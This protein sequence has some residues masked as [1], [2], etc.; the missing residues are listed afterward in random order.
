[1][2]IKRATAVALLVA[3]G[4][5]KADGWDDAKLKDRI[6][7]VPQKVGEDEVPDDHK[8]LYGQLKAAKGDVEIITGPSKP[9]TPLPEEEVDVTTLDKTALKSLI[10]EEGL[11]IK[12]AAED[13]L[14]DTQKAV[15]KALAK[16]AAAPAKPK[17]VPATPK[18]AA[19]V[20]GAAAPAKAP[21]AP[22]KPKAPAPAK[23]EKDKFGCKVG[24]I[25]ADVNKV[26]S[27]QWQ[28][29]D[30]IAK[31][32]GVSLDQ[33]RGRLYYA[34]E[35]KIIE[36]RRLIQYRIITPAEKPKDPAKA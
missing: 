8:E 31:A 23:V 26:L 27:K 6:G 35:K 3:L 19:P 20:K 2:Q 13:T 22:A 4:F 11:G 25:S 24:T 29:E 34:A 10:E 33:A 15:K 36:Y 17:K 16:K 28:D 7:Q 32:A 1:M 14:E 18:P 30:E 5:T 21:K 12:I 9:A